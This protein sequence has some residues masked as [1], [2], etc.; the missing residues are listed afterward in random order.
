[1]P[2]GGHDSTE[3]CVDG[4]AGRIDCYLGCH[5]LRLVEPVDKDLSSEFSRMFC[6]RYPDLDDLGILSKKLPV[7][8]TTV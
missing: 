8:F 7:I 1:M 6:L 4:L 3:D 2:A 5:C